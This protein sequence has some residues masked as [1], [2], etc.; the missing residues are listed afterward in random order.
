MGNQPFLHACMRDTRGVG[1]NSTHTF[2]PTERGACSFFSSGGTQTQRKPLHPPMRETQGR[3]RELEILEQRIGTLTL[4][5]GGKRDH[6]L[7]VISGEVPLLCHYPPIG[8]GDRLGCIQDVDEVEDTTCALVGLIPLSHAMELGHVGLCHHILVDLPDGELTCRI[9]PARFLI[10]E[11]ASSPLVGINDHDEVLLSVGQEVEGLSC[12]VAGESV[13]FPCVRGEACGC[14]VEIHDGQPFLGMMKIRQPGHSPLSSPT[15]PALACSFF[16]HR[17]ASCP[18][19]S[20]APV[21]TVVPHTRST[22]YP[23]HASVSPP[24]LSSH[25]TMP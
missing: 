22:P 14:A 1:T 16:S 11:D 21:R 20:P 12:I 18:V 8:G 23:Q 24:L 15:R 2:T 13:R 5:K 17:A 3:V 10:V 9:V 6:A 7:A 25:M 19:D 4:G